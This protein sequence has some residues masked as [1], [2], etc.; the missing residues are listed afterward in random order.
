MVGAQV[1][2]RKEKEKNH[3]CKQS[4]ETDKLGTNGLFHT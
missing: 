2:Q 1:R 3:S 4:E